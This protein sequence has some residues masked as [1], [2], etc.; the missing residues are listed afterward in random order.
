MECN[1]TFDPVLYLTGVEKR[2]EDRCGNNKHWAGTHGDRLANRKVGPEQ[3]DRDVACAS[4]SGCCFYK[5]TR[6]HYVT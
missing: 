5:K 1:Q 2:S 6:S 3:S 4:A